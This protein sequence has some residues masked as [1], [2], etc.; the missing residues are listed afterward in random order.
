MVDNNLKFC[1]EELE[2]TQTELGY[3]FGV[4]KS[5]IS[6]W[7]NGYDIIPLNKLIR[8]CNLYNYSLDYVCG[9][10][11]KN[12]EYKKINIDK[13][14]IGIK[15]K[16]LRNKLNLTQQQMADECSIS[17]STYCHYEIGISLISTITLY[18]ICKKYKLSMDYI[19]G[20]K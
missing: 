15:L 19:V 10:S 9:L 1:R 6:N 7:E 11:R 3:V 5:T 13:K 2:M 12:I 16:E 8:F 18:T 14:K 4:H 20:R 17:R